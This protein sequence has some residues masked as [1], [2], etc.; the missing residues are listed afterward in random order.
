MR[1][2]FLLEGLVLKKIY[3][4]HDFFPSLLLLYIYINELLLTNIVLQIYTDLVLHDQTNSQQFSIFFFS[5]HLF[6]YIQN[7]LFILFHLTSVININH[8][9]QL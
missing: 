6:M 9:K 4:C 1:I 8:M 2:I 7:Y 5:L 3:Y